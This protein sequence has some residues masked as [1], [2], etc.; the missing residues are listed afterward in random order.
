ML[1]P[2]DPN[3]ADFG[4]MA[5]LSDSERL[6]ISDAF[7]KAFVAVDE[8]GTE[9][10][11]VTAIIMSV[12]SMPQPVKMELNRPFIFAIYDNQTNSVLFLGRVM[13]PSN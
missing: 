5:E 7:H 1:A 6:F 9:A 2:F 4:G 11:A 3:V 8:N 10:A 13:N 12:Q